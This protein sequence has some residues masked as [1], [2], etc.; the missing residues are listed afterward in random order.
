MSAK[1][2]Q[3]VAVA[4]R[5]IRRKSVKHNHIYLSLSRLSSC[6]YYKR[7]QNKAKYSAVVIYTMGYICFFNE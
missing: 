7:F 3:R 5:T 2:G 6:H 4:F 1:S